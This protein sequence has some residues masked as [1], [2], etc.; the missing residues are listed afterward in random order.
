VFGIKSVMDFRQFSLR[1]L[2]K[3]K[4]RKEPRHHGVEHQAD[5]RSRRRLNKHSTNAC[6]RNDL[7]TS[8]AFDLLFLCLSTSGFQSDRLL[9]PNL[10]TSGERTSKRQVRSVDRLQLTAKIDVYLPV[11]EK[12]SH[13]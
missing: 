5:V 6:P 1:G 13:I 10:Q 12:L 9:G 2:D 4:R 3:V 7:K 8:A 11:G